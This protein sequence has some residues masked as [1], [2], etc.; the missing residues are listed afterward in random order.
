MSGQ[1]TDDLT[2]FIY[3]QRDLYYAISEI[4]EISYAAGWINGNEYAVWRLIHEGG[5]YGLAQW[6][7]A[8]DEL[9]RVRRAMRAA[10]CWITWPDDNPRAISLSAWAAHFADRNT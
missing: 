5:G 4:S 6:D 9:E 3:E 2:G 10:D 1:R 8:D 7:A